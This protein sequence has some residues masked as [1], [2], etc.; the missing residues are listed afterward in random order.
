MSHDFMNDVEL[1]L[2]EIW[3][4]YVSVIAMQGSLKYGTNQNEAFEKIFILYVR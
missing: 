1:I 3:F 4:V 2:Q